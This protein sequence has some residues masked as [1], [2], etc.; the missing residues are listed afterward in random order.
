MDIPLL[1]GGLGCSGA[2]GGGGAGGYGA[3]GSGMCFSS[4]FTL[5]DFRV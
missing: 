3:L 4:E 5:Q 2:G 1:I